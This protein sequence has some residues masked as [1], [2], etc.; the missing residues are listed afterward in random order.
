MNHSAKHRTVIAVVDDDKAVCSS[1]KF[2]LEI[3]GYVARTYE[4]PERFLSAPDLTSCDC[5]I[6]DYSLPEMDGLT[7][8]DVLRR[9]GHS[10][11]AILIASNPD[12]ITHDRADR[13]SIPIVEKPLL[14]NT[15][16][17][18]L[19]SALANVAPASR[20]PGHI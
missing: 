6:V 14:G 2:M 16:I 9:R 18:T 19:R 3:E 13:A 11:P 7:L 12:I 17:E 5:A 4:T 1:L 15:L 10:W 20:Q 8:V